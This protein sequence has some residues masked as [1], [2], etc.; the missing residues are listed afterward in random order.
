MSFLDIIL[1]SIALAMDCFAVSIASGAILLGRER[2]LVVRT[3]L[4]LAVL[5]GLFQALMPLLGWLA[6]AYFAGY[7]E[8]V[9][10]WIAFGMLAFIGLRMIIGAFSKDEEAH[11][12][13]EKLSSQLLL[14][15]A[16]SIDAL[17]VGISFACTGYEHIGQIF[18][19]LWVIGI[20][21]FIFSLLGSAIGLKAGRMGTGGAR[22]RPYTYSHSDTAEK[23]ATHVGAPLAGTRVTAKCSTPA[24]AESRIHWLPEVLGG[25]ILI[26]IGFKVLFSHLLG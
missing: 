24:D 10:H 25:V 11:F 22:P 4:Y 9:D 7:I 2:K 21:S 1:L 20:G 13:P 17:A 26:L 18:R 3:V 8:A 23:E 19:P 14:A 5:F 6:T 16:T 15:V 12:R